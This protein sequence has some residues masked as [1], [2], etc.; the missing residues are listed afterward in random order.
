MAPYV[1]I[2]ILLLLLVLAIWALNRF[3]RLIE[4]LQTHNR[5]LETHNRLLEVRISL[6]EAGTK[7]DIRQHRNDTTCINNSQDSHY[8]SLPNNNLDNR[9]QQVPP[10]R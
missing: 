9:N 6:L 1:V 7:S 2:G 8:V 10:C 5:L 4:V 3:L